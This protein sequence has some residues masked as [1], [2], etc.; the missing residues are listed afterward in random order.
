MHIGASC[1]LYTSPSRFSF[2]EVV[3]SFDV[4]SKYNNKED[5]WAFSVESSTM[6]LTLV[7][8]DQSDVDSTR[9][10]IDKYAVDSNAP[11]V[12]SICGTDDKVNAICYKDDTDHPDIYEKAKA[13]CR[14]RINGSGLCT[15]WLVGVSSS[16]HSLLITNEHCIASQST[17]ENS[18][19][20]F[21]AENSQCPGSTIGSNNG[22]VYGGKTLIKVDAGLD[23][24]LIELEPNS[25]GHA[26]QSYGYFEL[27]NRLPVVGE[28]IYIPQHAGGRMKQL[29]IVDT[30]QSDNL[31]KVLSINQ[32]GCTS[33]QNVDM[34]YTCDTE[35][36]SSGSPVVLYESNKIIGLHHCGGG[37]NGNMGVMIKNIV[38]EIADDLITGPTAAPV[39]TV[40]PTA[41][42]TGICYGNNF[43]LK[44]K[45]DNY[46]AETQFT[47]QDGNNQVMM[48]LGSTGVTLSANTE[49]S[50]DPVCLP[51]QSYTFVITDSYGDGICCSYGEGFYK[52]TVD[53]TSISHEGGEFD[54]NEE[55]EFVVNSSPTSPP[56]TN[57][58]SPPVTTPTS[59]P[60]TTPTSPPVT[61]P[62]SPP[63]TCNTELL[64]MILWIDS[65]SNE[66]AYELKKEDNTLVFGDA[67]LVGNQIITK[68]ACLDEG[69]QYTFE[70]T[71][72]DGICC[73]SGAGSY[74]L[75]LN[76]ELLAQGGEFSEYERIIFRT[77]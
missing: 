70:I 35:G 65:K 12:A 2:S 34:R 7:C 64:K 53:L 30:F 57:P 42:P 15:G 63:G 43:N 49:Y 23:Y 21:M 58:T 68:E 40:P 1:T 54:A 25:S 4:D 19:F 18:S 51:P 77:E 33:S 52:Y 11:S 50:F 36:G 44:L 14:V 37:C 73:D 67:D 61:N 31:C 46:P 55:T 41:S 76:G 38:D 27:E 22:D 26:H 20:Q 69:E 16:G 9:F 62:T 45:T 5:F 59:P 8:R 29:G 71:D 28:K 48:N 72:Q 75:T 47:L 39:P 13:A 32:N 3:Q 6:A 17:V 56:V 24:A 74:T 10:T 60:V 66:T